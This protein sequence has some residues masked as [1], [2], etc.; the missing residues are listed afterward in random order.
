MS[1][2][3]LAATPYHVRLQYVLGGTPGTEEFVTL[4][5]LISTHCVPGPLKTQLE[6][7]TAMW[8]VCDFTDPPSANAG[9]PYNDA[10]LSFNIVL[11]GP[12]AGT[13]SASLDLH[14]INYS[15]SLTN[16]H[17]GVLGSAYAL[18]IVDIRY[19]HITDH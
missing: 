18:A 5:D 8:G 2:T 11:A 9:N 13:A 7:K 16:N 14:S 15:G 4:S 19:V 6:T 12:T 17:I 3:K 1:I 10:R